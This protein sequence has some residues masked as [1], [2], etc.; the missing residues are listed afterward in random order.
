MTGVASARGPASQH[1]RFQETQEARGRSLPPPPVSSRPRGPRQPS[2]RR[3]RP[4]RLQ[5]WQVPSPGLWRRHVRA[6]VA[7]LRGRG[8]RRPGPPRR[9]VRVPP[10][11]GSP[12]GERPLR[13]GTTPPS[14][15]VPGCARLCPGPWLCS[16][17]CGCSAPCAALSACLPVPLSVLSQLAFRVASSA[18]NLHPP[19][20]GQGGPQAPALSLVTPP[21]AGGWEGSGG[22]C[23][24]TP[25]PRPSVGGRGADFR[26]ADAPRLPAG[27]AEYPAAEGA[28]PGECAR[29]DCPSKWWARRRP[30]LLPPESPSLTRRSLGCPCLRRLWEGRVPLC[31]WLPRPSSRPGSSSTTTSASASC[32]T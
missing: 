11:R 12:H 6:A 14:P 32:S 5:P 20:R 24:R 22:G 29:L 30:H 1:E 23:E 17:S 7:A 21:T 16:R 10:A 31:W 27:L 9:C 25:G 18:G 28:S 2:R 19:P 4:R 15:A 13:S 26:P 8:G 3:D